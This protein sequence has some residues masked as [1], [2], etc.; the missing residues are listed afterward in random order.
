MELVLATYIIG[1]T[2]VSYSLAETK[3]EERRVLR[4]WI[5]GELTE[6]EIRYWKRENLLQ[7]H[8]L[9]KKVRYHCQKE[10]IKTD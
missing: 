8:R 5:K 10:K 9:N 4:K 3:D 2:T 7:V 6:E 1:A